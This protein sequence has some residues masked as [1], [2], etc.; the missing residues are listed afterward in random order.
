MVVANSDGWVMVM[1]DGDNDGDSPLSLART[2]FAVF[3]MSVI[4]SSNSCFTS[5]IGKE[6]K[7]APDKKNWVNTWRKIELAQKNN[8]N[9]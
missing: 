4:M 8:N 1:D 5:E 7:L 6:N 9:R 2:L 3:L